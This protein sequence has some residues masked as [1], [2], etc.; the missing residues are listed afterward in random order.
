MRVKA[1]AVF[2]LIFSSL[3]VPALATNR[4]TAQGM[5]A[6]DR[7]A[8]ASV[9]FVRQSQLAGN[10]TNQ[11]SFYGWSLASS[12][13]TAVVGAPGYDG[14]QGNGQA[15]SVYV[16][17]KPATGWKNMLQTAE[18]SPSQ[19]AALAN[20]FGYA[21]AIAGDTIFVSVPGL[22]Q[23]LVY[24]KPSGGWQNMTETGVIQDQATP[25]GDGLGAS[26]AID[27][28][29]DTLAVGAP[30]ASPADGVF[31]G[32]AYVFIKPQ[33]GWTS[34]STPNG[35]LTASDGQEN[36]GLANS[37]AVS[38]GTV[39][40]GAAF[41]P[42]FVDYGAVY[43]FTKPASGWTNMTETA[44]LT[45]STQVLDAELGTSL[46][47]EGDTIVSGAAGPG[48]VAGNAY[49]F[50]KPAGGWKSSTQTA[51]LSANHQYE[52]AFGA[53]VSLSGNMLAVGAS[54]ANVGS[55]PEAGAIYLF[56][57]PTSG[58]QSTSKFDYEV[59]DKY[60]EAFDGLGYAIVLNG[61]NLIAGAPFAYDLDDVGLVD[62]FTL[63]Q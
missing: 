30:S 54:V 45:A 10:D 17:V 22:G 9:I 41:K 47:I 50:V 60:G 32:A 3:A 46:S 27:A 6:E 51:R 4:V 39:V 14:D 56:S 49:I 53:S 37:I 13:D 59:T 25:S 58:W 5:S 16:F 63:E 36:D 55:V 52:D 18:L 24:A 38:G 12:G 21:V 48:P 61:N 28:S 35:M 7:A 57:K 29:G 11:Y 19:N 26:I 23:V 44:K 1:A 15:G 20:G 43:V 8:I 33:G 34:T 40:V 31:A 2:C 42:V 62:V